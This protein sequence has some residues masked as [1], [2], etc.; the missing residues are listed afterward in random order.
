MSSRRGDLWQDKN[1]QK[2]TKVTK[3][4]FNRTFVFSAC[5]V[6]PPWR[7][8][9]FGVGFCKNACYGGTRKSTEGNKAFLVRTGK[10][11][12]LFPSVELCAAARF[13]PSTL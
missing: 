11:K 8:K 6:Y 10:E 12:S 2:E 4:D 3:G 5:S 9:A 7:A 1:Q 13:N